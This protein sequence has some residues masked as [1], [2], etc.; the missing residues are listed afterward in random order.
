MLGSAHRAV[1]DD[2]EQKHEF[3]QGVETKSEHD[4]EYRKKSKTEQSVEIYTN[5]FNT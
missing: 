4:L 2:D 5:G 1:D 3:A